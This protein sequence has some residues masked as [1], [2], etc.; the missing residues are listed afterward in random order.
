MEN[1][2]RRRNRT[3]RFGCDRG[4]R[5]QIFHRLADLVF[6][7]SNNVIHILPNVLEINRADALRAQ[8][9]GNGGRYL[10]GGELNDL[11]GH[12]SLPVHLP[13]IPAQRQSP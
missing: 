4:I 3:A 8:S 2:S 13:L 11:S 12:E 1:K 9:V 6:T 5:E 10:I 7:N